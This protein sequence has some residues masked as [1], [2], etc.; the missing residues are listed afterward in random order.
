MRDAYGEILFVLQLLQLSGLFQWAIR[1]SAEV[2]NLMVSVERV[3]E[4]GALVPEAA[5]TSKADEETWPKEG[6]IEVKAL[7]VRYRA[8]LPL[9]L[10]KVSFSIKSGQRI[11]VVGRTGSGKSTL[12]QALFRLLE[13]EEG[14]IFI[15]GVDISTLG[16]L[17]LRTSM[18]VIP[19]VPVLFSGSTIRENLDPFQSFSEKQ[20]YN[21]L[22]DVHMSDRINELPDGLSSIVAE[23]GSNFSVGQRQLLCLA[24]AI[25]R[26]NKILVLDEATANVDSRTD[27]LLQ[28]A[29]SKSFS[30]ATII[31]VAHRLDTVIDYDRILVLGKGEVL[32][33]GTPHELA[34]K[35]G[36]HFAS[37][38]DDTGHSMASELRKRASEVSL[39]N[40]NEG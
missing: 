19:Q 34:T 3:S 25:L 35:D 39:K 7:S 38:I 1:Q 15:D 16:L 2:V 29:V 26:K 18:S 8:N 31:A 17:K 22:N 36:G 20:I 27:Q 12:I 9:S 40:L 24:R 23:G 6:T 5:L 28:E 10:Q 33:F 21:A 30:G 37:M 32:A 14:Q 11:G 4:Y 13:A